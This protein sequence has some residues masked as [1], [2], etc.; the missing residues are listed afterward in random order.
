[1]RAAWECKSAVSEA[2]RRTAGARPGVAAPG[3]LDVEEKVWAQWVSWGELLLGGLTAREFLSQR[4]VDPVLQRIVGDTLV[5]EVK[6]RPQLSMKGVLTPASKADIDRLE[7]MLAA[8]SRLVDELEEALRNPLSG[9]R[10][11]LNAGNY[12]ELVATSVERYSSALPVAVIEETVHITNL[13]FRSGFPLRPLPLA[14]FAP[15]HFQLSRDDSG[16]PIGLVLSTPVGPATLQIS[17][18]DSDF[19]A[20]DEVYVYELR[21]QPSAA[22]FSKNRR[23]E[24]HI[25]GWG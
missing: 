24:F 23:Y 11:G 17:Q 21:L 5:A 25:L 4:T 10:K 16:R 9:L 14:P 18:K 2:F 6:Q 7:K 19:P 3:Q 20:D 15:E 8:Q 12:D 13:R 1:M 22:L